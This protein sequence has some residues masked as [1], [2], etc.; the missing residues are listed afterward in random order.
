MLGWILLLVTWFYFVP[1]LLVYIG[2]RVEH[3]ADNWSTLHDTPWTWGDRLV[4][5]FGA[6]IPVINIMI[7]CYGMWMMCSDT[8]TIGKDNPSWL[9]RKVWL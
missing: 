9:D 5:L 7:I 1:G 2:A 3:A 6:S 8:Y 4:T